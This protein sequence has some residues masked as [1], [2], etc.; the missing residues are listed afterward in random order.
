[1]NI[2]HT[3]DLHF[4]K[5]WF[6]WIEKEQDKYDVFCISGDFLC[7]SKDET[8]QEQILWVSA[9]IVNFKKPLIVCS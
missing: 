5:N 7:S 1:M 2:F 6:Q 9:W 3:T 8:V 4:N